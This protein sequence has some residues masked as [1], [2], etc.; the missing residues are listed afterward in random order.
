MEK[1]ALETLATIARSYKGTFEEHAHIAECV[2]CLI[3]LLKKNNLW[4]IEE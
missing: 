2:S 4:E 1:K 3:E